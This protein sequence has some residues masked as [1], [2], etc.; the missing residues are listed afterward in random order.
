MRIWYVSWRPVT[1]L[2]QRPPLCSA[3]RLLTQWLSH[4]PT[5]SNADTTEGFI[6]VGEIAFCAA[7]TRKTWGWWRLGGENAFCAAKGRNTRGKERLGSILR[8]KSQIT[9]GR[10][11]NMHMCTRQQ[12]NQKKSWT[13]GS[14]PPPQS[15][16]VQVT[17][18]VRTRS[19]SW[20]Y[21][22]PS[23]QPPHRYH[24]GVFIKICGARGR[25]ILLRTV[26][27]PVSLYSGP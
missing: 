11:F 5:R 21:K 13:F 12:T 23:C 15:R 17:H 7:K 1:S 24:S 9:C 22:G 8:R 26:F 19:R 20:P 25:I 14:H 4:P 3:Y 16:I 6:L 2:Q 10:P 27:S 18:I